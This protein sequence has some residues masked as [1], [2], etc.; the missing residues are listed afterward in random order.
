MQT[1]N[2]N[3]FVLIAVGL[4]VGLSV[5]GGLMEQ[6]ENASQMQQEQAMAAVLR[7]VASSQS[8]DGAT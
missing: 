2:W 5:L 3:K 6:T 7:V 4:T 1:V 8:S